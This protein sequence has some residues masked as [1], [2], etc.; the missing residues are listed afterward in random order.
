MN[1]QLSPKLSQVLIQGREEAARLQN[2]TVG[3]EHHLL[4]A[5]R[6][7]QS[8]AVG[9]LK[10]LDVA[11]DKLRRD[12][13]NYILIHHR[14]QVVD[15]PEFLPLTSEASAIVQMS[16]EEAKSH[17][18]DRAE[19]EHIIL[20]MLRENNNLASKAL[21]DH[22]VTYD[23]FERALRLTLE[24]R[25]A[26]GT[27]DEE[28]D[29]EANQQ[30]RMGVNNN[31][32]DTKKRNAKV[33]SDTPMLD[34]FGVD[35]VKAAQDSM[36]DPVIGR[37]GEIERIA[38][39]LSRR[40]KNNPI[41]I[42]DPGV[43][44]S[45]IVEGLALRIYQKKVPRSLYNKRVV[46]LD[47]SSVVAGTKY[48]GQ[49]EERI[50]QLLAELK[51]NKDVILFIDE[52]HTMVG[53]GSAPG[54]MDAANMLKPALA[55]G[56]VQCV[57]ATTIDEF[58]KTI[59][60]DGA[61]ERRFQKVIVAATTAE[62][63]LQILKNIKDKYEAHHSVAYSDEA[64][65]ACV[66]LSQRYITD[67]SFPDK[68]IDVMDEAGSRAHILQVEIPQQQLEQEALIKQL[69]LD[70]NE[71]VKEQ[72]YEL[73]ANL[74]DRVVEE[75]HKLEIMR[76]EWLKQQ[77]SN[78]VHIE[79]SQIEEVVSMMTGVP[80]AKM[81]DTESVR[82]KGMKEAITERVIGQV[83]AVDTVVRAIMRSRLGL[84][85]PN[86]PIGCFMFLGPTGVG[87][88]HLAKALAQFMFGSSDS[89]I[90]FDMSEYMEK[91]S[92]SRL[93]GAPPGYVGYDEGGQLTERVRRRPYSIILLDEIEKAHNDVFNLLL[94]VM[95][96]GRLT[97]SNG[98]TVD[99]KNTVIIMTSN[100]GSR[101]LKE[102]SRGIGYSASTASD[103][104]HASRVIQKA[105]EKQFAPEFLNRIDEVITFKPLDKV[106][107]EQ[108]ARIEIAALVSRV[109]AMGIMIKV[110]DEVITFVAQKGFEPQ[111]GARPLRRAI[112]S[113]IEDELTEAMMQGRLHDGQ[114]VVFDVDEAK[115][116]LSLTI[117]SEGM[118][119]TES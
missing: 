17:Y 51:K 22:N 74:R 60:K 95:D 36:L 102:F 118:V 26:Y 114:S 89:L 78:P 34:A 79:K 31:V 55:R 112:Q 85:D 69:Q 56:E 63:T 39:I 100:T 43:G 48:R 91:Y 61:L 105:L 57:G 109:A 47:M 93:V 66:A 111:Y 1:K 72:N 33:Q 103:G 84:K 81:A 90:R 101:Q 7:E 4:A 14:R 68:A 104:V 20:A 106:A 98:D 8:K 3:P 73:A 12:L 32:S 9:L 45:A 11:P 50:Q 88:T 76:A 13:E 54:S 59:E 25:G 67:R 41:L 82:L 70:K 37:E 53:A 65:A 80:V 92:V 15:L 71:A 75:E 35:L 116:K 86:R 2:T 23:S 110:S 108:I 99:F 18:S 40:K 16:L 44:K 62:E 58:R 38:Q 19:V 27:S 29:E 24:V 117:K 46:A 97:D 87:K 30:E 42:G 28:S 107:I 83:S 5:L 77:A 64:L 119:L 10:K 96:E 6:D 49:F 94:Q 52:I 115:D 113:L 21:N